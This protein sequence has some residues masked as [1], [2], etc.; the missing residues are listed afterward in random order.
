MT[1]L[2]EELKFQHS[3]LVDPS[4]AVRL[5]KGAGANEVVTGN[6]GSI[7]KTLMLQSKRIEVESMLN[8]SAA[9]LKGQPGHEDELLKE[10]PVLVD[11]L[12]IKR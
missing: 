8:L 9:S 11:R 1:Q 7:G 5:G 3:G 10:L 12:F 4:Q 6:I 2:I